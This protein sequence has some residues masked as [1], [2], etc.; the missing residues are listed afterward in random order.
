MR[1]LVTDGDSRAAL[2]I[3]RSLGRAGHEVV[4]GST[5]IRSLAGA[6]RYCC[7]R[8][9][10]P[11][12]DRYGAAFVSFLAEYIEYEAI[13]VLLPVTD[14]TTMTI[15][16][17]RSRI[18]SS[19]TLPFPDI[20]TVMKVADKAEM[21][22]L[23]ESLGVDVP[24]SMILHSA[25]DVDADDPDL[26][27]PIVIKPFKSRVETDQGWI[28]T[29]VAYAHDKAELARMLSGFDAR[30]YPVILQEKIVGPGMGVFICMHNGEML[31]GFSHRRLRE[32]PP[33]GGVSVLRESVALDPLALA[34]SEAMLKALKWQGVAMVEFK[35]DLRDGRPKLMEIN[36][37]F[38]GSLQL[39]IDAGVDFPRLLIES[40]SRPPATPI[41]DY[42]TGVRS[43][44]LWGDFDALMLRLFKSAGALDLPPGFPS[45]TQYLR[46]FLSYEAA[47]R[48]EVERWDDPGP[49]YYET[50]QWLGSIV[51]A[52]LPSP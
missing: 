28:Y 37:R 51:K 34:F 41:V 40:L 52:L 39:A 5:R 46:Q 6:S 11:D 14:I 38:W 33:S 42:R 16:A 4:V 8:V 23:A 19:C 25:A 12:P 44:W 36:G 9:R 27:F 49:M 50:G 3:T 2:A 47:T 17:N 1:I 7:A 13:D 10:Y 30:I 29:G 31:A 26:R 21:I 22:R 43:R 48:L 32:K 18:L 15:G 45:K 35:Q 24:R 20:D